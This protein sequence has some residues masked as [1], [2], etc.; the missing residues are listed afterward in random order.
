MNYLKFNEIKFLNVDLNC[1]CNAACPECARQRGYIYKNYNT[2]NGKYLQ[3]N[4]WK[5]IIDELKY[6]LQ[7]IVL[8]GNYGDAVASPN[9]IELINYAFSTC[10]DLQ[11]FQIDSNMGLKNV[12]FWKEL[13]SLSKQYG[14][15]LKLHASID[16]LEDTNHI[17]RRFVVWEKV[18]ENLK[19]YNLA[20]GNSTQK[21]IQFTWNKHQEEKVQ[22]FAKEIG[23]KVFE[24][25]KNNNNDSDFFY[26][27]YIDNKNN[28]NNRKHFN[29][30]SDIDS[31]I[32]K[33]SQCKEYKLKIKEKIKG[34]DIF[35][36]TKKDKGIHLNWDG[37]IWP[38]C[39][40][41]GAYY[42]GNKVISE[43][44]KYETDYKYGDNWNNVQHHSI[45]N[46]LESDFYKKD[47]HNNQITDPSIMCME[48]CSKC[49]DKWIKI[50]TRA[51][52]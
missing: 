36:L 22:S 32:I 15:K 37:K 52:Y 24:F 13:G 8:C 33:E 25:T 16:G 6:T 17:Y 10:K 48:V 28:W 51:Q 27:S 47:L 5:K 20:G 40:Y 1:I 49:D 7:K 44:V 42:N 45:E 23:C 46:I 4:T 26:N 3:T 31:S 14:H 35:C 2:P 18:C 9:I 30:L 41:G 19:A 11:T 38:C 50:H 12:E 34:D 39:W 29:S 21:M 43:S